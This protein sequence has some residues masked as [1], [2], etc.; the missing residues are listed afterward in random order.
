MQKPFKFI[1]SV[2]TNRNAFYLSSG[3]QPT[4]SVFYLKSGAFDICFDDKSEKIQC[5]DCCILPNDIHFQRQI[6]EPISFIY[7]KFA[8]NE[9][10]PFPISLPHG[11][12]KFK[13]KQRFC[14]SIQLLEKLLSSD[15][16]CSVYLKE[17]L[18]ED[19]LLQIFYESSPVEASLEKNKTSDKLVNGALAEI[20]KLLDK[21]ITIDTLCHI[22][23]TN[24]STL[25]F[26]FRKE[27]NCS[28]WQYVLSERM[29][30]ARYLIMCTNYLI[31]EIA[32]KCGFDN[33]YYFSSVF[34]SFYG[35]SPKKF[36]NQQLGRL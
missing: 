5:G 19:I 25:N 1:D 11:K 36:K 18:L 28:V 7:I 34:K 15:D 14:S 8:Y 4:H 24:A 10:C 16:A 27:L 20:D 21:K 22:L 29:K 26:K 30:R 9:K 2:I 33:V 32:V 6:I 23:G 31:S 35:V 13:N 17:H 12:I 3:Y